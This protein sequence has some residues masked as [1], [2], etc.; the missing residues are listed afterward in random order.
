MTEYEAE[1][2]AWW[3]WMKC[4]HATITQD[5]ADASYLYGNV[6]RE[7]EGSN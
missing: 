6:Y 5:N 2:Q 4:Q 7:I 1:D 3:P